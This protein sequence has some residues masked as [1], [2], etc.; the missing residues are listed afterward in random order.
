MTDYLKFD[1]C[2]ESQFVEFANEVKQQSKYF[3]VLLCTK[4]AALLGNRTS[5]SLTTQGRQTSC[6][7]NTQRQIAP[8][9]RN[10]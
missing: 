9:K 10:L 6:E 7:L 4:F 1:S 2:N 5:G 3:A 8:Q